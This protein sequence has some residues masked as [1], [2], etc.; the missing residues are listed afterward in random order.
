VRRT[1]RTTGQF[2]I[3]ANECGIALSTAQSWISVL[4]ASY[5]VYLLKPDHRNYSKRLVKTPKL[6]FYDTGLACSLL[7]IIQIEQ[8]ATH[9]MRGALFENLVINEFVK[10]C[11]NAGSE[12][13]LSFW[14]DKTGNEVDLIEQ[15]GEKQY[16]YEIKSGSTYSA[17]YFKGLRYWASHSK[18]DA[19]Q[20]AVIYTGDKSLIT[21]FG[22]VVKW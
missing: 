22:K 8:I 18:A 11:L 6:Y 14:R 9:F 10:K 19:I 21:S 4:E 1:N 20:C 13:N 15:I 17:E 3:V 5:I 7:N 16:G 12:P 2:I